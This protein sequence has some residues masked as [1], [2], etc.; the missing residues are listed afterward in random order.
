MPSIDRESW[1]NCNQFYDCYYILQNSSLVGMDSVVVHGC[2]SSTEK[3]T[4]E[5]G[6]LILIRLIYVAVS[7]LLEKKV[8]NENSR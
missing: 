2:V 3:Y 7:Q 6:D 8:I 5:M 4:V 1:L